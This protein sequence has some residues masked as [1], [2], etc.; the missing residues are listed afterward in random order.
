MP[1]FKYWITATLQMSLEINLEN[2]I[3][4]LYLSI[5]VF[6]WTTFCIELFLFNLSMI[7]YWCYLLNQNY[8]VY[9]WLYLFF[10]FSIWQC[11]LIVGYSRFLHKNK[12]ETCR[13]GYSWFWDRKLFSTYWCK[14]GKYWFDF[15]IKKF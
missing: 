7:L 1:Y 15:Q 10:I 4:V 14:Y 5:S 12:A 2:C 6:Q 8:H 13:M 9:F 3:N 11:L